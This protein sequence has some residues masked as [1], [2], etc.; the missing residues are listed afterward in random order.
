MSN[1]IPFDT[2]Q[3]LPAHLRAKFGAVDNNDLSAGAA[4]GYPVLSYKGKVWAVS[5][6]G[7]RTLIKLPD[8]SPNLQLELIILKAN[9][10]LAKVYYE[11][12]YEEGTDAKPDCYSNDGVAPEADSA[13]PQSP[14]CAICPHNQ[15]GSKISETQSKG[16]ACSDSRRMAVL[17]NGDLTAEPML[18]RCPA[19]S[20]KELTAYANALNKRQTPYQAV[21][22]RVSFDFDVAHQKLTFKP[23][24]W[25]DEATADLVAD[26]VDSDIVAQIVGLQPSGRAAAAQADPM[27]A[28]GE[29]PAHLAI[30]A[31]PVADKPKRARATKPA[32]AEVDPAVVDAAAAELERKRAMQELLDKS[33]ADAKAA[34]IAAAKAALAALEAEEAEPAPAATP[35]PV[36]AAKPVPAEKV[37]VIAAGDDSMSGLNAELDEMLGAYDD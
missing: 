35:A 18:L 27:D 6:G 31:D 20:L 1:I 4:G 34:K 30:A 19:G 21:V 10:A 17:P 16:K 23:I 33:N 9:P 25:V 22:T 14:K 32:P 2:N 8:G 3:A 13:S 12:G 26:L 24:G 36:A 37:T 7:E 5:K 11:H 15:W 29:R 28:L